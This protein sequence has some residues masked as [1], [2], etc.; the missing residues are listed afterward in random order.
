MLNIILGDGIFDKLNN[1]DVANCAWDS[2]AIKESDVHKQSAV[3]V[4]RIMKES[5]IKK[6]LDNVTVVMVSFS[7]FER[8]N[9]NFE[10]PQEVLKPE[11]EEKLHHPQKPLT[12]SFSLSP[13]DKM[14]GSYYTPSSSIKSYLS[15]HN[16]RQ[17]YSAT[18]KRYDSVGHEYN[19]SSPLL[20]QK[21]SFWRMNE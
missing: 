11:V 7:G 16:D 21:M 4:E 20:K 8:A 6:S 19:T 9:A 18:G 12:N 3:A 14:Q 17:V 10:P 13:S 15:H 5:L 2:L 1:I